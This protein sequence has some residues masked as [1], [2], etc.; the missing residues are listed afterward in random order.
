MPVYRLALD[1]TQLV[2]ELVKET[3][4]TDVR[5][6]QI[7]AEL[8]SMTA[9]VDALVPTIGERSV[10]IEL[11]RVRHSLARRLD[12][13]ELVPAI[14]GREMGPRVPGKPAIEKL[15]AALDAL[16]D[17]TGQAGAEGQQWRRYL[18]I[19]E[20]RG[21]TRPA[22]RLGD[23]DARRLAREVAARLARKDLTD[24]QRQFIAS[25]PV[26]DLAAALCPW[27]LGPLDP[28]RL[29][30]DL[31]RFEASSQPGDARR[32]ADDYL[33]SVPAEAG[34]DGLA[35]RLES[36]YRNANMRLALSEKLLKRLMPPLTTST[37]PV[38][39]EILGHPT[40]GTST[41]STIVNVKLVPNDGRLRVA[42]E[43]SGQVLA[44]TLSE[45]GPATLHSNSDSFYV[46]RKVIDLD[47]RGLRTWPAESD[48][49]ESRS[50]LRSV[51]TDFD[52]VPLVGALVENFARSRHAEQE[53]E[54][55]T[56]IRQR[57]EAQARRKMDALTEERIENINR[58]L[59]ERVMEPL[60][61]LSLDPQVISGE[62]SEERLTMRLRLACDEQLAGH[63]P[64]PRAGR[65]PAELADPPVG[66]QQPVRTT[67]I[68]R[69][70][71]KLPELRKH[72]IETFNFKNSHFMEAT[73]EDVTITF[74]DDSAVRV[75]CE[76]G[77]IEL[78]L[79]VARL[80]NDEH[81]WKNFV[82]RVYYQPQVD[83]LQARLVRDGSV[84]LTGSRLS[85]RSQIAL[86]GIFSKAFAKDRDL[87]LVDSKWSTDQ[88]TRDLAFSQFVIQDGWIAA[89]VA[90]PRD[91]VARQQKPA[92]TAK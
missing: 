39:D 71:Y 9:A 43:A 24:W 61:R 36:N 68:G 14:F 26:A 25:R 15:T 80:A 35:E 66:L 55:R 82:V 3:V 10:A 70:T 2:F 90:E 79:A 38:R 37:D 78:N 48:C 32:L 58:Q 20:L 49:I 41:T 69:C 47:V 6:A 54:V 84:Q 60:A 29:L 76:D 85:T 27:S 52:G 13:W 92:A 74:A 42:L 22:T 86:R 67:E 63:T 8:R 50:R 57:V 40:R 53:G 72:I 34:H 5:A 45:A 77:R 1:A 46:V 12:V 33:Q 87:V 81:T 16:D 64:R 4:P 7:L 17:L 89:A 75:R 30:V 11:L 62:T 31:E 91:N 59:R 65:Q 73:D 44:N 18:A 19:A 88:R 21:L 83:G 23:G 51:S 56:V 28:A